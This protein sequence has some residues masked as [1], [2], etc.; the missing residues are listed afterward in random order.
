MNV[1]F[2]ACA[3]IAL[4]KNEKGSDEIEKIIVNRETKC[5]VHSINLCEVYYQIFREFGKAEAEA[6]IPQIK[7][8]E[9]SIKND[10]DFSFWSEAGEL[11]AKF[12]RI[13][14]ADCLGITL[15]GRLKGEFVTSDHHEMD[16]LQ[17]KLNCKINFFR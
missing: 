12:K 8:L 15:T 1:I 14:L 7:S 10:F 6:L 3:L 4:I 5:F 2:D 16:S 17:E 13:S 11:K 9:I